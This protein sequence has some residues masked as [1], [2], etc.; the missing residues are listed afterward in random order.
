MISFQEERE[1]KLL[2]LFCSVVFCFL[3]KGTAWRMQRHWM[4]GKMKRAALKKETNEEK[5]KKYFTSHRRV[6]LIFCSFLFLILN[7]LRLCV[8]LWTE[9]A[10]SPCRFAPI[11]LKRSSSHCDWREASFF[12][13]YRNSSS[14]NRLP[15]SW[16][17]STKEKEEKRRWRCKEVERTK[18]SP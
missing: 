6:Q 13:G 10:S 3:A 5:E 16:W 8:L 18:P 12:E 9:Q 17:N 15:S 7:S 4:A 11:G 14:W 1:R 2:E